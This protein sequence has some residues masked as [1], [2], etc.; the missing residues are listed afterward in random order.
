MSRFCLVFVKTTWHFLQLISQ[1]CKALIG[2]GLITWNSLVDLMQLQLWSLEGK[3]NLM[4][5]K[6]DF[7]IKLLVY[8]NVWKNILSSETI[9]GY[10]VLRCLYRVWILAG[11]LWMWYSIWNGPFVILAG[12]LAKRKK[13][14]VWFPP[15]SV[16]AIQKQPQTSKAN[17][18]GRHHPIWN[19]TFF[20]FN[21]QPN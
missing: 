14:Y 17:C 1:I 13:K 19:G 6:M 15:F 9:V 5:P 18:S 16:L 12:N 10:Q 11:K 3:R 4:K 21:W 7:D 2:Y 8:F 20:H